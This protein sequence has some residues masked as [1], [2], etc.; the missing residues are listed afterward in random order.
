[1]YNKY[2][3]HISS[4]SNTSF[5]GRWCLCLDEGIH[6][7]EVL[8]VAKTKVGH[9]EVEAGRGRVGGGREDEGGREG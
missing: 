7:S 3:S 4:F 5:Y 2:T 6:E 9:I 8:R 1:M